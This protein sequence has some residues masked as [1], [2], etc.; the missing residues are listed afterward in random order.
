MPSLLSW[1]LFNFELRLFN[2]TAF[3]FGGKMK[4]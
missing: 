2:E 1:Y 3:T 4:F